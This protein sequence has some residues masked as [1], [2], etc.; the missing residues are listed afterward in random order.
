MLDDEAISVTFI[1]L[2]F[3]GGDFQWACVRFRTH[4]PKGASYMLQKRRYLFITL[5]VL[6]IIGLYLTSLYSYLLFH[7]LAEFF[8]IAVASGVFMLAWNARRYLDNNY[9]LFIGIAYLFVSGLDLLHTLS[10]SGMGIFL[11]YGT[12]LPTQLWIAAR[13]MQSV[14]LLLAPFFY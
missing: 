14:S 12:N 7:S 13:F 8:S 3:N 5:G 9:L 10:Y 2:D 1:S 4:N 11:G 6:I